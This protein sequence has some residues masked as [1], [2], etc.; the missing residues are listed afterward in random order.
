MG[1][2]ARC[3]L[4]CGLAPACK[5]LPGDNEVEVRAILVHGH[6]QPT[7]ISRSHNRLVL[8]RVKCAF[9]RFH[10]RNLLWISANITEVFG[11]QAVDAVLSHKMA[12]LW[13]GLHGRHLSQLSG[14]VCLRTAPQ[15]LRVLCE[16][17]SCHSAASRRSIQ[18]PV[19][20][21]SRQRAQAAKDEVAAPSDDSPEASGALEQL[22]APQQSEAQAAESRCDGHEESRSGQ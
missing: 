7:A 13:Q 5:L 18:G 12:V 11:T 21:G 2:W 22:Q 6:C 16:Q 4:G 15:A 19:A 17:L 8:F 3:P 20:Q 14:C 10:Q 9:L 1:V